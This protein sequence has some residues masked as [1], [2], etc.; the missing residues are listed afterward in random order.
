MWM[1]DSSCYLH[2]QA[3]ARVI[4]AT[5]YLHYAVAVQI[6]CLPKDPKV[7]LCL[8]WIETK[9]QNQLFKWS[10]IYFNPS[11]I[12]KK[13]ILRL[14]EN[15][16]I[17]AHGQLKDVKLLQQEMKIPVILPPNHLLVHLL[18]SLTRNVWTLWLQKL[19]S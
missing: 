11:V 15:G 4:A 7:D 2:G 12:N 1:G 18:L 9:I 10:K 17:R 16:I 3:L 6:S 5:H 8:A 13:L 19:N 14:D